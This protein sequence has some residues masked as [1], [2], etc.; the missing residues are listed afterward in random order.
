MSRFLRLGG[1]CEDGRLDEVKGLID[2]GVDVNS[3]SGNG[4]TP[5]MYAARNGHV[6]IVRLLLDHGANINQK[7]NDGCTVMHVAAFW[8]HDEVLS[9]QYYSFC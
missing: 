3:R 6:D 8:G 2:E 4:R 9:S 7:S 5:L 1:A